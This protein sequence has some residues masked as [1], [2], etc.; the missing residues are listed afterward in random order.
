VELGRRVLRAAV[1]MKDRINSEVFS[2][3]SAVE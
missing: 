3:G 1:G 2:P